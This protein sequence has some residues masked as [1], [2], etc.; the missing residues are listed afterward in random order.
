MKGR[1]I[2]FQGALF[3]G[4]GY[5]IVRG[6]HGADLRIP[7]DSAQTLNLL[8]GAFGGSVRGRRVEY[9]VDEFGLLSNIKFL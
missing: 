5:L 4:I 8:S 2:G 3:S 6:N 9:T 7:C 1:I